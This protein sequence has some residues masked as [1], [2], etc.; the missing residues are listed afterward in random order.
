VPDLGKTPNAIAAGPVAEAGASAISAGFD[1]TL[2]DGAGPIPSLAAIAAGD[3]INISVLD[4]YELL[5]AIV[6]DPALYGFTDVTD[7]CYTGTYAGYA[8]VSDPGTVCATP[9]QYLF[10]DG[11]HP[12]AAGSQLVADAALSV[13][14]PE[15]GSISLIAAGLLGLFV[16][17]RRVRRRY[18]GNR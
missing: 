4:T 3:S 7:P 2:V 14:T 10:W 17:E 1:T 9:N 15:P 18:C 16:A 8:D 12:T 6:A 11:Q 13:I 5:D